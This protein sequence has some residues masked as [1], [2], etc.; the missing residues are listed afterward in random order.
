MLWARRV[1]QGMLETPDP[2]EFPA[3]LGPKVKL[4]KRGI[5]VHQGLLVPQARKD[6]QERTAL[7]GTWVP[8]DSLEI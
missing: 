4:V 6:P 3:S 1:S 2:Q 5:R 8:Q 7:R